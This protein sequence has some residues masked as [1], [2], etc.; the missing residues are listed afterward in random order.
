MVHTYIT[1]IYI[2]DILATTYLPTLGSLKLPRLHRLEES[3][4]DE[5]K[6]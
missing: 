3:A 4:F 2:Y 6:D 1:Y 5:F